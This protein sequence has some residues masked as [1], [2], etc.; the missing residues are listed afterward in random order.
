MQIIENYS[1]Q[2]LNTFRVPVVAKYFAPIYERKHLQSLVHLG[3]LTNQD[4]FVLGGGS[5]VLFCG[6]YDGWVLS[7]EMRGIRLLREDADFLYVECQGG[8]DWHNF[9]QY[10]VARNW[11]GLENLSL[12]PGSVGAAPVQNIGAY[13]VELE[14]V[15]HSLEA[16]DLLTGDLLHFDKEDCGFSYRDSIFKNALK[17]RFFICSV[18]F[19]LKKK[20]DFRLDYGAVKAK[21]EERNEPL[22]IRLVSEVICE[23][24]AGKLPDP[25]Q[26]GNCGSFFKN[27]VVS[28]ELAE[29]IQKRYAEMPSYAMPKG[30]KIPA[31]WLIQQCGWKGK[32]IED[33]GVYPK[34][35]L[36]LVNWGAATGPEIFNLS[37]Q[38][39][40]S[41][42]KEFGIL[43]EREVNVLS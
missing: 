18:V 16:V 33:A 31:G 43:L 36:V 7:N 17:G 20:P 22:S 10:C 3:Y 28:K 6:D 5:N 13:G 15:F 35:A 39:Q 12:I 26:L 14:E 11:A 42:D 4:T 32:R 24:R 27:P 34:H 8:E 9:V 2:H 41:V 40:E 29:S 21:I 1:I 37:T 25:K 38:I 23:I 30:V 19:R